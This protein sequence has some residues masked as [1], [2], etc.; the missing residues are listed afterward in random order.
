MR[1]LRPR[2]G[3]ARGA[4]PGRPSRNG[5]GKDGGGG[6]AGSAIAGFLRTVAPTV[7]LFLVIRAFLIEAFRIPSGSMIPTLLVGR[8]IT[9]TK[10]FEYSII[11]YLAQIPG[12][13]SAAWLNDRIDR[14]NTI[15]LYLAGSALS[16][17]AGFVV[18]RFFSSASRT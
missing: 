2:H 6:G 9:V 13:F 10:S 5:A 12:Y 8:G 18:L 17:A 1:R 16:A 15:A 4:G 3:G 11:I 14:K 7:V